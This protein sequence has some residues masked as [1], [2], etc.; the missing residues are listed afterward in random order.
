MAGDPK[1]GDGDG[2]MVVVGLTGN[3]GAGKS[4]VAE[5]WRKA[6]VSVASADELARKAVA[7]GSR[8]LAQVVERF[9]AGVLD[10]DGALDRD[11]LRRIVFRDAGARRRLEEVVHPAVRWL[12]DDWTRA[13]R[14]AGAGVVA[15]EVPLLFETGME[16]EVDVVVLVDAP[17]AVRRQRI[18]ASRGL[19]E[20]EASAVMAAQDPV[21]EKR[22]RAAF[23]VENGGS[24]EELAVRAGEVL[25]AIRDSGAATGA[26]VGA[27][28]GVGSVVGVGAAAGGAGPKAVLE[29]LLGA[30]SVVLT[31]HVN[32]DGDGA[33]SQVAVAAF[34]RGRG[35][36]AWIVN[37][38]PFPDAFR[39]LLPD[40]AWALPAKG[41][42]AA[43]RC[44]E[45]DLAVV[46]DT[47]QASRIGRVNPL[48]R[49]LPKVVVDHHPPSAGAVE[50]LV[51]RDETA[52][53]TGAMVLKVLEE[54]GAPW[55]T[56]SLP[57]A[58]VPTAGGPE[59]SE[60][61]WTSEIA[62]A[63][64]VA[65][66]TDTGGFRFANATPECFRTAARLVELGA[67]PATLHRAVYGRFRRRRYE[68]LRHSLATLQVHESGRI[69]WMTVPV[70]PYRSL[71]ATADDLEGFVDVPRSIEGVEAALL[72]RTTSEGDTKV[73]LR[74]TGDVVVNG[75]AAA[76]GGGG[77]PRAAGA[78]VKGSPDVVTRDVV[79]RVAALLS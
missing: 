44:R 27:A 36:P 66:M 74:S 72:F 56:A 65:V 10:G 47:S 63:L 30:A 20:A 79:G 9:G 6:G 71:G 45:A 21:A 15:W 13:Q 41:D 75:I 62:S 23:V 48:I 46:L 33:G 37:P 60:P 70:D 38:T 29:R 69:A 52:A 11:A 78:V 49:R 5:L 35:I 39:F 24:L 59:P 57:E 26:G 8:V 43:R 76:L 22:R 77:H 16:R 55:A 4:A 25:A 2:D 73:S 3:V 14:K 32:A 68:L 1:S 50:G 61:R 40:Q 28:A 51:F 67:K 12:R 17:E 7:P 64:Y 19:S 53:A 58:G 54:V 31:T 34:L 42:D 18:V